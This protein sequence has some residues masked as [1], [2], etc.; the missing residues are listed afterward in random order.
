MIFDCS[1]FLHK[2]F[3]TLK[4]SVS[5][6]TFVNQSTI[7]TTYFSN[8]VKFLINFDVNDFRRTACTVERSVTAD[9]TQT[10]A[11]PNKAPADT[12]KRMRARTFCTPSSHQRPLLSEN[13]AN[14]PPLP[15][16]LTSSIFSD[17]GKQWRILCRMSITS[18]LI[19]SSR[20]G[21]RYPSGGLRA[22]TLGEA[23]ELLDYLRTAECSNPPVFF[24]G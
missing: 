3:Y 5:H 14:T 18:D 24:L 8:L 4:F 15:K 19:Q 16:T 13:K 10:K 9:P 20:T 11:L 23:P 12:F 21:E 1:H 22:L 6:S 7:F 2:L 17:N